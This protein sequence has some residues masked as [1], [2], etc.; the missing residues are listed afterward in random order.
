M[1]LMAKMM[2]NEQNAQLEWLNNRDSCKSVFSGYSE[3][4]Y[5]SE[6]NDSG[7]KI[8]WIFKFRAL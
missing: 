6:N 8:Q 5:L 4:E 2:A 7:I 1:V 3:G